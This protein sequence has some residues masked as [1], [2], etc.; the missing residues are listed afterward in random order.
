MLP[1][2][3]STTPPVERGYTALVPP[4]PPSAAQAVLAQALADVGNKPPP[5]V[6]ARAH[7]I[8]PAPAPPQALQA[9]MQARWGDVVDVRSSK[10]PSDHAKP[11]IWMSTRHPGE[12][13]LFLPGRERLIVAPDLQTAEAHFQ[14]AGYKPGTLGPRDPI[15][16]AGTMPMAFR[17]LLER[18]HA[19]T[20]TPLVIRGH[21]IA[22][23]LSKDK[24]PD[25]TVLLCAERGSPCGSFMKPTGIQVVFADQR[26]A[27]RDA[28][29]LGFAETVRGNTARL[30]PARQYGFGVEEVVDYPL[31]AAPLT[32]ERAAPFIGASKPGVG[33]S[34]D[35]ALLNPEA[36]G[37][38]LAD[39]V[40]SLAPSLGMEPNRLVCHL[41]RDPA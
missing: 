12:F 33:Q 2:S 20:I 40:D 37:V 30:D 17:V 11:A 4:K 35:L 8:A 24:R 22:Y 14:E 26:V 31:V 15:H 18:R 41:A 39:L 19:I 1:H 36:R 38:T 28:D 23:V 9:H 16:L 27:G 29:P 7:S 25:P 34:F 5:P 21:E 10:P 3:I 6:P 13:G 32:A